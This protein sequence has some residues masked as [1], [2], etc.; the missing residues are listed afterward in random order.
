MLYGRL[1]DNFKEGCSSQIRGLDDDDHANFVRVDRQATKEQSQDCARDGKGQGGDEGQ[2]EVE[3][4]YF[5][6]V[7]CVLSYCQHATCS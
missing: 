3:A 7:L 5:A 1:R 4:C 6:G 2:E